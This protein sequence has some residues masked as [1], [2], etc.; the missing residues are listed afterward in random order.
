MSRPFVLPPTDVTGRGVG[1]NHPHN[2]LYTPS[3]PCLSTPSSLHSRIVLALLP[4]VKVAS[5]PSSV[6]TVRRSWRG[7][8]VLPEP[9]TTRSPGVVT[10]FVQLRDV[11]KTQPYIESTNTSERKGCA[12]LE[13]FEWR[14]WSVRG[15]CLKVQPLYLTKL[16]MRRTG[17]IR[18]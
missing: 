2:P 18:L 4:L 7:R 16:R 10:V 6:A 13:M 1:L 11:H 9:Y 3:L 8:K 12:L 15:S 17:T 5:I 14:S